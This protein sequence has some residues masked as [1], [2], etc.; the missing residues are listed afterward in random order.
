MFFETAACIV[1][2]GTTVEPGSRGA[3]EAEGAAEGL[4]GAADTGVGSVATVFLG[5][6]IPAAAS[7]SAGV[8]RPNGPEP[9]TEA[10]ST[11]CCLASFL[12]KG[13]ATVF[14]GV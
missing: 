10:M 13:V 9:T 8:I 12:A 1:V 6:A 14:L 3:D 5:W 4:G 2:K 11:L 7:T